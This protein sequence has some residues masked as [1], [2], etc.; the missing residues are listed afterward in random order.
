[1]IRPWV[2]VITWPHALRP[3]ITLRFDSEEEAREYSTEWPNPGTPGKEDYCK[4]T[5]AK[6]VADLT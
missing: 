2:L 4:I 3:D 6:V 1:M 5:L